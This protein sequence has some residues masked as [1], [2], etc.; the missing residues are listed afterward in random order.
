M[1]NLLSEISHFPYLQKSQIMRELFCRKNSENVYFIHLF[2]PK[3]KLIYIK[4]IY[5]E[6]CI[7]NLVKVTFFYMAL[8][9][10]NLLSLEYSK[11]QNEIVKKNNINN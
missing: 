7:I 9:N 2:Y 4:I 8:K 10:N 11:I 6:I 3:N 1:I 5:A